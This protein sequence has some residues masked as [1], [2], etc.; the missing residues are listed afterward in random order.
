MSKKPS[1][2]LTKT[3][4]ER[5]AYI[6]QQINTTYEMLWEL[7]DYIYYNVR[8]LPEPEVPKEVKKP[9]KSRSKSKGQ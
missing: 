6:E 1:N 7:A 9:K 4:I 3:T 8:K 2:L 5:I